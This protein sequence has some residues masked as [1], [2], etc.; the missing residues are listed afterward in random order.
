MSLMNTCKRKQRYEYEIMIGRRGYY[1][2][3]LCDALNNMRKLHD[4]GV[5]YSFA[6]VDALKSKEKEHG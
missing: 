1:Y 6:V 2:T 3:R 5:V 4:L